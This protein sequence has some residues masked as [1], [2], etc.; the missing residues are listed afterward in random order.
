M[1]TRPGIQKKYAIF[2]VSLCIFINSCSMPLLEGDFGKAIATSLVNTM[3]YC[4]DCYLLTMEVAYIEAILE[5]NELFLREIVEQDDL[6]TIFSIDSYNYK[7]RDFKE[8]DAGIDS[9]SVVFRQNTMITARA[10]I[11][12]F[13]IAFLDT[14]SIDHFDQTT[15]GEDL[16]IKAIEIDKSSKF[17]LKPHVKFVEEEKMVVHFSN[18][19]GTIFFEKDSFGKHK[20]LA[21][22]VKVYLSLKLTTEE[23]E[24][25]TEI[26]LI[27]LGYKRSGD[28]WEI[29]SSD[30]ILEDLIKT[31]DVKP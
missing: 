8:I 22:D 28:L 9:L 16:S 27:N 21:A 12:S 11:G 29:T 2:I 18:I 30:K 3:Q 10:S 14:S 17:E 24:L 4:I 6:Q 23:G 13:E 20:A 7:K 5:G 15:F 1:C 26:H 31:S 25:I 19:A